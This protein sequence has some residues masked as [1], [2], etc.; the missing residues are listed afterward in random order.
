ME[1]LSSVSKSVSR[2]WQ[3]RFQLEIAPLMKLD[4]MQIVLQAAVLPLTLMQLFLC[5][6]FLTS[7]RIHPLL[8]QQMQGPSQQPP[9][10]LFPSK[11]HWMP[12]MT[13]LPLHYRVHPLYG[14]VSDLMHIIW[15]INLGQSLLMVMVLFLSAR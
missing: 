5:M 9:L 12:R 14:L 3:P 4:Q 6:L 15:L 2:Q 7:F 10:G 1:S 8:V 13:S 11:C